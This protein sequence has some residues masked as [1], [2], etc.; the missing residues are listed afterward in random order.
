MKTKKKRQDWNI[1]K[2]YQWFRLIGIT[3]AVYV[4]MEYVLPVVFPFCIGFAAAALLLPLRRRLQ[5][6]LR[7]R[8]EPAAFVTVFFAILAAA[9]FLGLTC[10]GAVSCGCYIG[11]LGVPQQLLAQ[12][13]VLWESCC[14][15]LCALVGHEVLE[16]DGYARLMQEAGA[17]WM[18]PDTTQ[19]LN[20]W[21]QVSAQTLRVLGCVLVAVVST[22]LMLSEY[23]DLCE[24]LSQAAGGL[25]HEGFGSTLRT[26]GG[27][28]VRAQLLIMLTITL[29]C[30]LGLFVAR[31]PGFWLT[32]ILIGLCDA[33]PFLGTGICFLP[34]ALWRF[35]NG[36]YLTGC[37][38]LVLYAV[39]SFTRQTLE[40]R[41]IG[42]KIG[43]PPLAVLVSVYIGI[44]VYS[45]CG[46][47]LGPVSA[48]LIW[49]LYSGKAAEEDQ[50]ES[51]AKT[52]GGDDT[53]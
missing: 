4:A 35:V 48:F 8:R 15:R 6:R 12:G 34:W 14:D 28:Y 43:V 41:L 7:I 27:T 18:H 46:F 9:A 40:P 51:D 53:V 33:L 36:R 44:K 31:E 11:R 39:T 5:R 17:R 13:E 16:A 52:A 32:G 30:V 21:Q 22:T 45:S 1:I 29:I 49:Q 24:W 38:F 26:V 37:W 50:N 19:L 10:Y 47:L 25:F 20:G 42:H 2:W 23:E 3:L